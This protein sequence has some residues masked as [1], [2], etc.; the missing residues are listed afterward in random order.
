MGKRAWG[1][2]WLFEINKTPMKESIREKVQSGGERWR[3][4]WERRSRQTGRPIDEE[5]KYLPH[6]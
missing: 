4:R 1:E 5:K 6:P 3:T 2:T